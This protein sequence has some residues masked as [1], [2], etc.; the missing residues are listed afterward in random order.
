MIEVLHVGPRLATAPWADRGASSHML[1]ACIRVGTRRR[2]E[3][4]VDDVGRP[5]LDLV[6]DVGQV[7][8]DYRQAQELDSPDEQD[9]H[10]ERGEATRHKAGIEDADGHLN[11]REDQRQGTGEQANT[12]MTSRGM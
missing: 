6:V 5:S 2:V 3:D 4:L 12:V 11:D 10:D 7:R 9:Q 1:R 8:A